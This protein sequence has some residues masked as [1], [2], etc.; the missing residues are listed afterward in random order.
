MARLPFS[1]SVALLVVACGSDEVCE[2]RE[3]EDELRVNFRGNAVW[4]LVP[5]EITVTSGKQTLRCFPLFLGDGA[6]GLAGGAGAPS[7]VGAVCEGDLPFTSIDPPV[8]ILS[9]NPPSVQ[10]TLE[11]EDETRFSKKLTPVYAPFYPNGEK[12]EPV[13]R[14]AAVTALI[15]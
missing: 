12:C 5:Y 3:C 15:N 7:I 14:Q 1:M 13:C 2:S 11:V 6:G 8:L 9:G 4:S 10:V